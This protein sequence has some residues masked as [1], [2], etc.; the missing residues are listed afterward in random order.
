MSLSAKDATHAKYARDVL[1]RAQAMD[2]DDL[3]R[4][5]G[6]CDDM[7]A[8]FAAA[9]FVA[10]PAVE[11]P[12]LGRVV[13]QAQAMGRPVVTTDIGMLANISWRRRACRKTCGPAGSRRPAIRPIS[14]MRLGIALSLN[15]G[16]YRRNVRPRAAI[17]GVYVFS[18]ER[19]RRDAVGLYVAPGARSLGGWDKSPADR[20]FARQN[21]WGVVREFAA[22]CSRSSCTERINPLHSHAIDSAQSHPPVATATRPLTALIV[23]PSL[24]AGAADSGAV[25]LVRIL[26]SAGHRPI[27]VSSGGR[28]VGDVTAAGATFIPMNVDSTNPVTIMRNALA[29][30][31]IVRE[32]RC[33]LIHAHARAPGWSAYYAAKR[34][35]VPFLTSWYKG[36]REQN[37]L[38]RLYNGVM[39]RGDCVVAISD[40][41]AELVVERYKTPWDRITVIPAS[42]DFE[43]FDPAR[44]SQ[45]RIDAVRS[46]WGVQPDTKVVLVVG[47]MLRRK[48]HH[49]VVEAVRRLKEMGLKDFMCVFVGED[50]GKSRYSGELWDLV[51]ATGTTEVIRMAGPTD[52]LP[53]A[54]AAATVVVNAAIQPEGLQRAILEARGDGE[55]G[56]RVRPRRRAGRGAGAAGGRRRPHDRTA[57]LRRRFGRAGRGPGAAVLAAAGRAGRYRAH[58]DAPGCW[59]I[60]THRPPPSRRFASMR[61]SRRA[62]GLE[63]AGTAT[64]LSA[65][66]CPVD[67]CTSSNIRYPN[68]DSGRNRR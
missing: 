34:T 58:A 67:P 53:A 3:I 54:L 4:M 46:A 41:I 25:Q 66:R 37:V 50:Q 59:R 23:T 57:L 13:A 15:A 7:P 28:M 61:R 11:P 19:C 44:V 22:I 26:A 42:I 60:S 17:R 39:A 49:V 38:K 5:A 62:D 47:R 43:R 24:H 14:R 16:A 40:Q 10:V 35:G 6:H 21:H 68:R 27:V 8:A 30:A 36:F 18:G 31:R 52:D 63:P 20:R 33:D 32:Q 51:L 2:V 1:K 65:R 9:D 55:A 45:A 29:M 12:L 48:G 56:R 64:H